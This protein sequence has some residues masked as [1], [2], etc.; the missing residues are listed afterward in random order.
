MW[1]LGALCTPKVWAHGGWGAVL[2][3]KVGTTPYSC[4]CLLSSSPTAFCLLM[5]CYICEKQKER[6]HRTHVNHFIKWLQQLG[7]AKAKL[8]TRSQ[9]WEAPRYLSHALLLPGCAL[10]GSR[11]WNWSGIQTRHSDMGCVHPKWCLN[12]DVKWP[13]LASL[14]DHC[15]SSHT[16]QIPVCAYVTA[17]H[18]ELRSA[19]LKWL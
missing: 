15:S 4:H 17:Q 7:L 6:E 3:S 18:A 13:L 2:L 12:C 14:L 11:N 16:C 1:N 5:K 9:I 8:G 10:A 19:Q